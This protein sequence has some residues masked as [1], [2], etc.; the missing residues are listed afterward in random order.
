[1]DKNNIIIG[2]HTRYKVAKKLVFNKAPCIITDDLAVDRVNAFH[3]TDNKVSEI[4][5]C[6]LIKNNTCF[7]FC[8]VFILLII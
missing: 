8:Y 3:L 6:N 1:M 4:A 7:Y 5:T 2:N